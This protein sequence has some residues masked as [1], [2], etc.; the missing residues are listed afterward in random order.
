MTTEELQHRFLSHALKTGKGAEPWD[1][2]AKREN[3]PPLVAVNAVPWQDP[4]T[5]LP[6]SRG[7]KKKTRSKKK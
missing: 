1:D 3:M 6:D 4:P 5:T 2:F 7:S